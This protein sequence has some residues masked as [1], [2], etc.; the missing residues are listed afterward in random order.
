MRPEP[1]CNPGAG[2]A[3]DSVFDPETVL[4]NDWDRDDSNYDDVDL[5]DDDFVSP[6]ES[7]PHNREAALARGWASNDGDSVQTV[8]S[9]QS[10]LVDPDNL[11]SNALA[12][13]N[14]HSDFTDDER[15]VS[16]DPE[17]PSPSESVS[18]AH[19][20]RSRSP[21]GKASN[22]NGKA[23]I[24]G[25]TGKR[26]NDTPASEK[27]KGKANIN[28]QKGKGNE[29]LPTNEKGKVMMATIFGEK[30][31]GRDDTPTSN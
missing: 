31:K 24:K 20:S 28:G 14:D 18:S 5:T 25:Q 4:A 22:G 27:G 16:T 15:P 29:N 21:R 10:Q 26:M 6:W 13:N 3:D 7:P 12:S 2:S 17:G 9:H 23:N 11:V 19:R 30:G 1:N 8:P